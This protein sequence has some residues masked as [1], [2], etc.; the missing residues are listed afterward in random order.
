MNQKQSYHINEFS[1]RATSYEKYNIIQKEVAKHLLSNIKT[2]PKNILDLGCGDGTV[3]KNISWKINNFVGID[4]A[5]N[6]CKLHPNGQNITIINDDFENL[7]FLNKQNSFNFDMAISSSSLQ[8][9]Q[10]L[11]QLFKIIKKHIPEISFSIFCSGTFQT[12]Y[13]YT[14]LENFLPN[15]NALLS[16]LEK[17]FIFL[18]ERKSYKLYF[19]DNISKFRYIKKSGVSGGKKKLNYIQTKKLIETYPHDYLEFEVLFI[20]GRAK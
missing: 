12:I 16:L 11:D 2:K 6:M 9:A 14:N 18:H 4:K 5:K 8:W 20:W 3:F 17:Y 7:S 19:N 10:N 13:N 1:K 15:Y